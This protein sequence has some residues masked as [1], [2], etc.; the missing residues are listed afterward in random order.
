MRVRAPSN[1]CWRLSYVYIGS[2]GSPLNRCF[3]LLAKRDVRKDKEW[4]LDP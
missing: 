4:W 2:G 3:S 1:G